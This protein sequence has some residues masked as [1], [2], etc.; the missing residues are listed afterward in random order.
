MRHAFGWKPIML[1]AVGAACLT[2]AGRSE[3]VAPDKLPEP[4]AR[5]FKAMFPNGTIEKLDVE[6]EEGVMVYDFEFTAGGR[7]KETDI[8]GD[9]TMIES[10]LVITA[11]DIPGPAMKGILAAAKGAKLG[12]M[13]WIET[14]Y[15]LKAG[16]V[17]KLPK[18]EIHYAAELSRRNQTAEVFVDPT[19]KVTAAPEWVTA[20]PKPAPP[21]AAGK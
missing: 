16:K 15:E 9:G 19:G 18:A 14:F 7:E 3:P 21:K 17:I 2:A 6:A 11:K 8:A 20:A 13:E 4:V 12:R 1:V 5:T 10:T